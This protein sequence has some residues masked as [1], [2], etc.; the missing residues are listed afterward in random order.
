LE[1]L[2]NKNV[3]DGYQANIKLLEGR[4]KAATHAVGAMLRD[5]YG[6]NVP[7]ATEALMKAKLAEN[8]INSSYSN[9]KKSNKNKGINNNS[10][11]AETSIEREKRRLEEEKKVATA[12]LKQ[13]SP[14]GSIRSEILPLAS[15]FS[16]AGPDESQYWIQWAIC[17]VK[18]WGYGFLGHPGCWQS[19]ISYEYLREVRSRLLTVE[20]T[21]TAADDPDLGTL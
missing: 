20:G 19:D 1:R 17:A 10:G 14:A 8:P 21:I 18:G 6:L 3:V 9:S 7:T 13:A 11:K 2:V 16:G 5:K 15:G 12:L 4:D